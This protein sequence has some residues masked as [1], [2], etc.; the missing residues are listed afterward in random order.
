LRVKVPDFP[1]RD[2]AGTLAVRGGVDT[3]LLLNTLALDDYLAGV[4]GAEIEPVSEA[5]KCQAVVSRTYALGNLGRHRSQGFDFCDTTHCQFYR[6]RSGASREARDAVEQTSGLALFFK[7][8]LAR[9]F[10]HSTC[11]GV[12]NAGQAAW[13]GEKAPYLQPVAD[14]GACRA[15]PHYRWQASIGAAD[16]LDLL[17][18]AARQTVNGWK[19]LET[20]EGEWVRKIALECAGGRLLVTGEWFH[21]VLGRTLGWNTFKSSSFR[22]ERSGSQWLFRGRGLGHGVGLCQQG[23]AQL[24]RQG[25]NFRQIAR[26]YFPGTEIAVI[27]NW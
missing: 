3:L 27:R 19:I 25:R 17:S 18:M 26:F 7:G 20:G 9:V 2:F 16:L 11:G 10:F 13:G 14:N 6:G 24:A 8:R 21:L 23:A 1:A 4:I 22:A 15:S 12:T 5:L